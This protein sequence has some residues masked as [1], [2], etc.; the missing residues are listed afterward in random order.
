MVTEDNKDEFPANEIGDTV[1]RK[2]WD[3]NSPEIQA[4]AIRQIQIMFGGPNIDL[5]FLEKKAEGGRIGFDQGGI[6]FEEYLK[7]RGKEERKRTREKLFED[8]ENI[9]VFNPKT[10]D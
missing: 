7:G 9:I 8:C 6:S 5:S 3:K 1:G 4:E 2:K 10:R